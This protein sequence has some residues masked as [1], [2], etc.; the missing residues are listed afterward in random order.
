MTATKRLRGLIYA[1]QTVTLDTTG[2]PNKYRRVLANLNLDGLDVGQ[3]L[4]GENLAVPYDGGK[5]IKWCDV[6]R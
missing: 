6:L 3:S 5:R 1:A 2:K 4:I